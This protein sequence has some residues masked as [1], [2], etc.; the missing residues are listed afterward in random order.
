MIVGWFGFDGRPFVNV[1]VTIPR[2]GVQREVEFLVDTG[3]DRTCL[4][5]RD[6]ANMELF[7]EVLRA[8]DMSSAT[9]IGGSSRYFR[10]DAHIEFIDT[11][12]GQFHEHAL[13]LGI[14]DLSDT[15]LTIPSL[16]GRDILNRYNMVYAPAERG[17]TLDAPG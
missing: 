1:R 11:V 8:D 6:A 14:A 7:P 3:S 10:E 13:S 12:G 9:G 15:P 17:L 16:L 4:N 5:H 2:L